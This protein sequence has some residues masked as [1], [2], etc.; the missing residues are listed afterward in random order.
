MYRQLPTDQRA[1]A[2]EPVSE[3]SLTTEQSAMTPDSLA[4]PV[5]AVASTEHGSHLYHELDSRHRHAQP[6]EQAKDKSGYLIPTDSPAPKVDCDMPGRRRATSAST[7]NHDYEDVPE[8]R[9]LPKRR[10][11][12]PA[13]PKNHLYN[14]LSDSLDYSSTSLLTAMTP[15]S[16][17]SL[18]SVFSALPEHPSDANVAASLA[19]PLPTVSEAEVLGGSTVCRYSEI[20]HSSSPHLDRL[21]KSP[22][23]ESLEPCPYASCS[24]LSAT[25]KTSIV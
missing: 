4:S 16:P 24:L 11:S 14:T 7:I 8:V 15:C 13:L 18:S 9:L 22:H 3:S 25:S 12:A 21:G 23:L 19:R 10:M 5:T 20:V 2:A 1:S 17:T 6:A